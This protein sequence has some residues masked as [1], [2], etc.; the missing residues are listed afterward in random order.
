MTFKQNSMTYMVILAGISMLPPL[1]IDMN[2]PAIPDIESAFSI[3]QGQGSLTLSLFLLGF[4]VAP[5]IG[6]PLSDRFGRRPTVLTAL[7]LNTIAAMCC[8]LEFSFNF[9]LF[10]RLVQG[11]A[12]GVC[13]LAPLAILRDIYSGAGARTKL[14]IIMLVGGVAPLIAPIFGGGI[15][16]FAGWRSIYGLQGLLSLI[17]FI[18]IAIGVRETL[19]KDRRNSIHVGNIARGYRTLF[20]DPHF[21]GFALPQALGFGC[22]FSY[23]AGSP[24]LMLGE[25]HLSEQSYS[26]IFAFTSFGIM[27]GSTTSGVLGRK[28]ISV[29][30]I[31][32]TSLSLMALSVMAIFVLTWTHNDSLLMLLPF[33]FLVMTC[34][35]TAQPNA[36]SEA[37]A[38]WGH[39]A[40]AASGA[41]N[42]LQMFMGAIASAV[43]PI[44]TQIWS[45]GEAMSLSML[46]AA[47]LALG[48]Y[49]VMGQ[50]S[51]KRAAQAN[52][53]ATQ[54]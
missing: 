30:R 26:L 46:C 17:L 39:M 34:F 43:A 33:L 44:L 27:V 50:K 16:I 18:L 52:V 41:M 10:S 28:E 53:E 47:L 45:P 23:I 40:G 37:V 12:S 48:T 31:I 9:L 42:S 24:A 22:I 54:E 1:C 6:G 38:P 2:L 36:M 8:T 35:G 21:L 29:R 20:S 49:F 7:M 25:M 5:I 3:A 14:S 4:S 15:L 19:P 13:V 32:S 51:K 11:L